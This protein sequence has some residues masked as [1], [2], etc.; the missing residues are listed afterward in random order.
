[1]P[2]LGNVK[3]YNVSD[4]EL[5]IFKEFFPSP[6]VSMGTFGRKSI[7]LLMMLS[8]VTNTRWASYTVYRDMY[9][10][11][12]TILYSGN[13]LFCIQH[14]RINNGNLAGVKAVIKSLFEKDKIL[15]KEYTKYSA[16]VATNIGKFSVTKTRYTDNYF[17]RTVILYS[18]VIRPI[19]AA[20]RLSEW[21]NKWRHSSNI[22]LKNIDVKHSTNEPQD[23]GTMGID[24]LDAAT[25]QQCESSDVSV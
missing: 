21:M 16:D 9:S 22:V 1:M 25:E 23:T 4:E 14:T 8:K 5:R 24:L 17:A 6:T 11:C 2:V 3:M 20:S 15:K 13:S 19:K 18:L 12:E 7:F 10:R